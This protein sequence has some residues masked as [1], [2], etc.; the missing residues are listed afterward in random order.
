MGNKMKG[1]QTGVC[2]DSSFAHARHKPNTALATYQP[3]RD[4]FLDLMMGAFGVGGITRV[5]YLF[6]TYQLTETSDFDELADREVA[7]WDISDDTCGP[8]QE[9]LAPFVVMFAAL[10]SPP[11]N[12]ENRAYLRTAPKSWLNK[13][14][15]MGNQLTYAFFVPADPHGDAELMREQAVAND[16]IFAPPE[17]P[18]FA[19]SLVTGFSGAMLKFLFEFLRKK[20]MFRWLFVVQDDV[21]FHLG[22]FLD[23]LQNSGEPVNRV[24][25]RIVNLQD[26]S[27]VSESQSD[28]ANRNALASSDPQA[29]KMVDGTAFVLSRDLFSVFTQAIFLNRA[30]V[31]PTLTATINRWLYVFEVDYRELP[32]VHFHLPPNTCPV[33]GAFLH[34]VGATAMRSMDNGV[35]LSGRNLSSE[36]GEIPPCLVFYEDSEI[37]QYLR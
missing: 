14:K 5:M 18:E 36:H 27:R 15:A 4:R 37:A 30:R 26:S 9:P 8:S 20:F 22:T 19:Q 10:L 3:R 29:N 1:I 17:P 7:P 33:D 28:S 6:R 25:G 16:M 13:L 2:F 31:E 32:H 34:P 12:R 24:I 35:S 23:T 11:Q 21:H